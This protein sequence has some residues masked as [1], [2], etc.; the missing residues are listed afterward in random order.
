MVV[1]V[2]DRR[3]YLIRDAV[4]RVNALPG[5]ALL[6][7]ST[8]T[9]TNRVGKATLVL[10]PRSAVFGAKLTT[11]TVAKTPTAT[12]ERITRVRLPRLAR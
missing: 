3:G 4:V 12:A 5:R 8:A 6:G 9:T 7:G 11:R 2:K 10:R 1:T